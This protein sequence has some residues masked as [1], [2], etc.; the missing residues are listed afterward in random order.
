MVGCSAVLETPELG[1]VNEA[2]FKGNPGQVDGGLGGNDF[3]DSIQECYWTVVRR[4][5]GVALLV[6]ENNVGFEPFRRGWGM[7][8]VGCTLSKSSVEPTWAPPKMCMRWL[9]RYPLPYLV[10]HWRGTFG[11]GP[12]RQGGGAGW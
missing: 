1:G 3:V 10:S 8:D 4:E 2:M 11:S 6:Q 12:I 7:I 9:C 5:L